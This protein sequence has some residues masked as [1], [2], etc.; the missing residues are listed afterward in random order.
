VAYK[1][2]TIIAFAAYGF[3]AL[4]NAALPLLYRRITDT[5]ASAP[6]VLVQEQ[7]VEA[8]VILAVVY[9]VSMVLFRAGDFAL[10]YSQSG[11]LKRVSDYAFA[12]VQQ[13][14]YQFFSN[15]FAGSLVAKHRRFVSSFETLE[16][17]VLFYAWMNGISLLM[18]FAVL[19]WAAP[20]LGALF[21]L[22]LVAYISMSVWFVKRKTPKDIAHA[23]AQSRTTAVL[24]DA[25]TNTLT[26]KMFASIG[27]EKSYFSKTTG[28]EAEKR[29]DA[30]MFQNI[31]FAVQSAFLLVFDLCALALALWLWVRGDIS[32]GTVVL[33]VVYMINL[34]G[35]TWNLSRNL[36]KAIQA[37]ADAK[38]MVDLL[39]TPIEVKDASGSTAANITKGGIAFK[40][41][42]FSYERGSTVFNNF[43]L[44]IAPRE[45]IGL[46]GH[47]GAGKTTVTKL[48]LR[49]ADV[50]SGEILIDGQNIAHIT[51]D[52][53]RA[54]ISY[55]PQEPLLFHRTLR[56]NIAYGKP[57]ATEEEIIEVAKRAR[58][59]E[60]IVNLPDGY[61]TL[62][63]E[64]GVKLSGG[65]RQRVAIARAMLKDAPILIL[66]EA[67]SSL[68]SLSERTIQ[69]AFAELMKGKTALV[70]AHRLSTISQM[71]RILVFDKG[72]IVEEGTH[73]ELVKK[74]GV[75]AELWH[76]QAGGF[77]GE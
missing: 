49:F 2:T 28:E 51:Q 34:F 12:K 18:T 47:S 7:L 52:E 35:M 27:A 64:R 57:D 40:D 1:W 20:L 32:V 45:K 42:R 36:T 76:E 77:L 73:S 25:I 14:S 23:E 54:H 69:E 44:T 74:N 17:I 29:S 21:L 62:V 26:I 39:D 8:F 4:I 65:E 6:A 15:T 10:T 46:V 5:V 56:E 53:L 16:D 70:V 67:T 50:Q 37:L 38:E 41:V 24:A 61:E 31:Q 72:A 43:S 60:F 33:V 9:L 66:D 22:W 63:G 48:L 30:W 55:V 3:A 59:H 13:H 11:V 68:D 75:Y 58:A 71:D 19:T